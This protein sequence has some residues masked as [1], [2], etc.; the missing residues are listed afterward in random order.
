[1]DEVQHLPQTGRV[2]GVGWGIRETATTTCDAHD[3][4]HAGHGK[5][6]AQKLARD[7]RM[8][9]RRKTPK[10]RPDTAGYRKDRR[11]TAQVRARLR[12]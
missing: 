4:P 10:N 12:P 11:A 2:I 3:L 8:M 7:Q 9:A 6:A 5:T 1:M